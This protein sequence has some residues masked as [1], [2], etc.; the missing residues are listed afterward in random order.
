M[1]GPAILGTLLLVSL[2][3]CLCFGLGHALGRQSVVDEE[4]QT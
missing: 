2:L 4:R 3:C 1:S